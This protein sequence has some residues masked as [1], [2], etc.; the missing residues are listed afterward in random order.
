M[1]LEGGDKRYQGSQHSVSQLPLSLVKRVGVQRFALLPNTYV[2]GVFSC[3]EHTVTTAFFQHLQLHSFLRVRSFF[4]APLWFSEK[5]CFHLGFIT[6]PSA[7]FQFTDA[8]LYALEINVRVTWAA[9]GAEV[10]FGLNNHTPGKARQGSTVFISYLISFGSLQERVSLVRAENI[11]LGNT[12]CKSC[13]HGSSPQF[14]TK[15]NYKILK[16]RGN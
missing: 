5:C 12:V 3:A 4:V 13:V 1:W 10:C 16:T 2:H 15:E 6:C 11:P 8:K 7:F 14:L 9:A